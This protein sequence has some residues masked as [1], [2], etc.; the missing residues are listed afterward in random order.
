ME[1]LHKQLG[2]WVDSPAPGSSDLS[3]ANSATLQLE[4]TR[5]QALSLNL[6]HLRFVM[7]FLP[8]ELVSQLSVVI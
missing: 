2:A 6:R 3:S 1:Q 8:S 7:A 4:I 5:I